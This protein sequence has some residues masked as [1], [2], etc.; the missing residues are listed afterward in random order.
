MIAGRVLAEAV[1]AQ[2]CVDNRECALD[3][4]LDTRLEFTDARRTL[5]DLLF[6]L[7]RR[8]RACDGFLA[9]HAARPPAPEVRRALN[10]AL[11]QV[12]F[13]SGIRPESAVNVAVDFIRRNHGRSAGG[14]A[15]ALL[16][17]AVREGF[18]EPES[19]FPPEVAARWK[20]RFDAAEYARLEALWLRPAPLVWRRLDPAEPP[21]EEGRRL[22]LDWL[23][24]WQFFTS[25]RPA[26]EW[27]EANRS[28]LEAGKVYLQDPAT[29]LA[30]SLAPL[31]GG[32]RVLDLCAAPGGKTLLLA[33]GLSGG[34]LTACD[35]SAERMRRL[36]ENLERCGVTARLVVADGRRLPF[37]PA[38]RFDLILADVPCSNSGVF[39]R[40]P[41]A[42]W[43]FSAPGLGE[44]VALERALLD[45]AARRLA[46]G[47]R[48]IYSSCSLEPE[49]NALQV[50]TWLAEH[51]EFGLAAERQLLPGQ[52]HDGAYAAVLRSAP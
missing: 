15:N 13:Q 27:L 11:I 20:R 24:E 12:W 8:R 26:G 42:L 16:R 52:E 5:T 45:A 43:R 2:A 19:W 38:E 47:G 32:E 41:D 35:R 39:R 48:L 21:E 9:L 10:A 33:G 49:E 17:R 29:A 18:P 28:R 22:E 34:A 50:Q 31:A 7:Y 6:T 40:R 37:D 1:R 14:F 36:A 23:G 46:P 25:E 4:F 44:A 51:P 3:D 30:P